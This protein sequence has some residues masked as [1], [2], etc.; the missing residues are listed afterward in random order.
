MHVLA[1]THLGLGIGALV[2]AAGATLYVLT[3]LWKSESAGIYIPGPPWLRRTVVG[4][5]GVCAFVFGIAAL[6][7]Y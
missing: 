2:Y 1:E 5:L 4:A 6:S 7:G 3:P